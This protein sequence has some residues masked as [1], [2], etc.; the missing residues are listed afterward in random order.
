MWLLHVQALSS[1]TNLRGLRVSLG[2]GLL[3]T[4]SDLARLHRLETLDIRGC[5]SYGQPWA[6]WAPIPSWMTG[7]ASLRNFSIG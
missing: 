6:A 3:R 4:W 7:L 5:P 1:M 2:E